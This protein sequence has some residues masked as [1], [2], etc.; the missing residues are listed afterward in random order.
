MEAIQECEINPC[1]NAEGII[2]KR[3]EA[4]IR[5]VRVQKRGVEISPEKK[6]KYF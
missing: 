1:T 6:K 5:E 3:V 2:S 4:F